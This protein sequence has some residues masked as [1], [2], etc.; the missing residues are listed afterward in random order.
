MDTEYD[1]PQLVVSL[2][3]KFSRKMS[4]P[5]IYTKLKSMMSLHK[6]VENC[7]DKAQYAVSQSIKSLRQEI[8]E[9]VGLPFF[10]SE[11]VEQAAG[12]ADNVAELEVAELS[13]EYSSYVFDFIEVRGERSKGGKAAV[14]SAD[15]VDT[16]MSLVEQAEIVE[17]CCKRFK[18]GLTKQCLESIKEDR[19]WLMKQLEKSYEVIDVMEIFLYVVNTI[20]LQRTRS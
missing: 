2:L 7:G 14:V 13:R 6:I 8:D 5:I 3:V 17:K 12:K 4:E 15:R 20:F 19:V 1:N 9:K 10:S 16:L 18:S 11:T